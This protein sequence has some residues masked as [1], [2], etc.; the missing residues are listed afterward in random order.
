MKPEMMMISKDMG[1]FFFF[2]LGFSWIVCNRNDR[3][4][5]QIVFGLVGGHEWPIYPL[6]AVTQSKS[7]T[8]RRLSRGG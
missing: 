1:G 4:H 2:F 5:N 8:Q 6:I 7:W 3:H